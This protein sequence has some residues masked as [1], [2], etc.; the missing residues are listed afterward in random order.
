MVREHSYIVTVREKDKETSEEESEDYLRRTL[1][2]KI[3][4]F[5]VGGD[6]SVQVKYVS[7]Q[8]IE[9]PTGRLEGL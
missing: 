9:N 7:S 6:L 3:V 8:E 2:S 4:S 1:L 5:F